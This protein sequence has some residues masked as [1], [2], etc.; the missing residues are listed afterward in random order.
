MT[1]TK[2]RFLERRLQ[3]RF[4]HSEI[5]VPMREK[6]GFKKRGHKMSKI[7]IGQECSKV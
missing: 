5:M 2:T 1:I 6:N 4:N 7:E 3:L